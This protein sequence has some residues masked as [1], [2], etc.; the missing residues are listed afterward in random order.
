M[1]DTL[2]TNLMRV[3]V[4]NASADRGMACDNALAIIAT[5]NL[6][7]SE[8][9]SEKLTE[10]V[11]RALASGKP[12]IGNNAAIADGVVYVSHYGN[13]VGA[14]SLEDGMAVWEYGEREFEFYAAPAIWEKAVYLGG[15]D[16]RFH[17]IDR[18]TGKGLWEYRCRGRVDSSAVVCAGKA[19]IFGGDDGYVYALDLKEGKE[20]W[21]YEIGAAVKTSPAVAG[22]FV[23]AGAD[24]GVIYAFKNA[25]AKP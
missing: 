23:I 20:L 24:D 13:R 12:Y 17:A 25:P 22:D 5:V 10:L 18:I 9:L 15:R 7:Q 11:T 19:V 14:Y 3:A 2:L 21:Q 4:Q 1:S 16:R 6:E 8:A